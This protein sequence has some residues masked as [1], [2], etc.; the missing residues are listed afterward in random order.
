MSKRIIS[1]FAIIM[2][3]FG[4]VV[5]ALELS[6]ADAVRLTNE[7]NI[8]LRIAE[9][10][11]QIAELDFNR[12]IAS[13]LMTDSQYAK[14]QAEYNLARAKN[15]YQTSKDSNFLDIFRNYTDVLSAQK[16]LDIRYYET[17]IAEHNYKIVQE[18]V[19]IG[20]ASKLDDLRE[21]NRLESAQRGEENAK[22]SLDDSI[23][24][25]KRLINL[26]QTEELSLITEFALPEF[27]MDLEECISIALENSFDVWDRESTLN[28][29]EMQLQKSRIDGTPPIDITRAELNLEITRLNY[30][31]AQE[32]LV[33]RVTSSLNTLDQNRARYASA[34]RELEISQDSYKINEQQMKIGLI[35]EIQLLDAKLALLRAESSLEDARVAYIVSYIQLKQLL[36]LDVELQ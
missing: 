28:L 26:S 29:Q 1:I 18:K 17:I 34:A 7:N 11:L 8:A 15:T 4:G 14:L 35:T 19:R 24:S 9:L 21:T 5:S 6:F 23:R 2:L 10:N 20:D 16:N 12:S 27:A 13:N 25:L 33:E 36:G 3:L 30:E 22:N 31:R 32:D